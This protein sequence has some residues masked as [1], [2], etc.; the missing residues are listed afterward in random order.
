MALY[1]IGRAVSFVITL[2]V[3][4]RTQRILTDPFLIP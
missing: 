3:A 2:L 4:M 1:I